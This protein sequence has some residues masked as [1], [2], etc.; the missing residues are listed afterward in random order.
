[1]LFFTIKQ[2][3]LHFIIHSI[4]HTFVQNRF[5]SLNSSDYCWTLIL[6]VQFISNYHD[7]TCIKTAL[8]LYRHTA[9]TK[10]I[11]YELLTLLC[12][13]QNLHV[14]THF[15]HYLQKRCLRIFPRH[16]FISIFIP[17]FLPT[18][19]IIRKIFILLIFQS[20]LLLY[21]SFHLYR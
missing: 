1:M 10:N 14:N 7:Q 18:A 16:L 2:H 5:F 15:S 3:L 4:T 12:C 8:Q 9:A 11:F 17:R 13:S 6:A 20:Q 19:Q 21:G